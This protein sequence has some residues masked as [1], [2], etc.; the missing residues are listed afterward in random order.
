[1]VMYN[2]GTHLFTYKFFSFP[3]VLC[4]RGPK[5]SDTPITIIILSSWVVASKIHFPLKETR[6]F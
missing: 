5:Q 3:P 2:K 6:A 4:T 1:M